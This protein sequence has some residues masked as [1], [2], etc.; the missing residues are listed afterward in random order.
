MKSKLMRAATLLMVLT[1]MTSCFVSSTFA[2]YTTEMAGTDTARVAKFGVELST[3]T[4]LFKP[5]YDD[6]AVSVLADDGKDVIAPGTAG[7]ATLFTI[8]G[9]PEV[10]VQVTVSL[11]GD[12]AVD[13]DDLTMVTLPAGDYKDWTDLNAT[14]KYNLATDYKPVLWTLRKDGVDIAEC[15]DVNLDAIETYL[16]GTL[17]G[18][19]EVEGG[20]GVKAFADIV[21]DYE[22]AWN[23]AFEQNNQADTT[24]GQIAAGVETP[25]PAG[26]E[27][28]ESFNFVIRVEQVD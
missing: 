2:K 17:S 24:L 5:S 6:G 18:K 15:K 22:L 23:W 4:D 20:T 3:S 13:T 21:G 27:A 11:S 10:D 8:D 19:Y 14:A 26:H 12:A 9:A 28:N 7:T 25:A 1:L 16:T